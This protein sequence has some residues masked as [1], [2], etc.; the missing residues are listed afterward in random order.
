MVSLSEAEV[1]NLKVE[2]ERKQMYA[3][4]LIT[5]IQAALAQQ[6]KSKIILLESQEA[7]D[8]AQANLESK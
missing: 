7:L 8:Q 4:R 2:Y 6:A 5:Q 3:D 1:Q